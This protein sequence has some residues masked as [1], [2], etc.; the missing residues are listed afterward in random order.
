MPK[1]NPCVLP[2]RSS[3]RNPADEY[4]EGL[5]S[6][7]SAVTMRS[8]LNRM[9]KMFGHESFLDC[10]WGAMRRL[11]CQRVLQTLKSEELAPATINVYLACMKGV[12]RA[13]WVADLM[14]QSAYLKI[15]DMTAIRY[16]RLPVGRAL[17][18][19]ECKRLLAACEDGTVCGIRDKAILALMMGCGLRRTEVVELAYTNWNQKAGTL[20]L[21]GKGNKERCVYLPDDLQGVLADWSAK[22]GN[23]D[24]P[25]F[26]RLKL[27]SP[28]LFVETGL[29]PCSIYRVIKA[30]GGHANLADL[31][32]HDLRRT[33]ATRMLENGCDLFLLQR[34]MGHASVTTTARYD[35]RTE[36]SREKVCRGLRF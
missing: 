15:S 28:N 14:P 5:S 27:G 22:R 35:R 1:T 29:H 24:G 32:P 16:E 13:A 10:E 30:R 11:H 17:T 6:K 7:R 34:A 8:C 31:T 21:I 18:L 19:R 12:A 25:M 9:A 4:L 33:F 2:A 23:K 36:K 20:T 26:W 3:G